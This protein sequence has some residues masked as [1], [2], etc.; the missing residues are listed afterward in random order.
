[1]KESILEP[2]WG[3]V[4][5]L[6]SNGGVVRSSIKIVKNK[7]EF[8]KD[9]ETLDQEDPDVYPP[10]D[11]FQYSTG[12]VISPEELM[13][14]AIDGSDTLKVALQQ[15]CKKY[16]DIFSREVDAIPAQVPQM[17]LE[18]AEDEWKSYK[19]IGSPRTQTPQAQAEIKRQ[20][21]ILIKNKIIVKS[22]AVHY[23][24]VVLAPKP[25]GK[26]RMCI[27]YKKLNDATDHN[28]WPA[29]Y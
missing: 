8:I 15:L 24:K 13:P 17:E 16:I 20:V 26:W 11:E 18:V 21:D 28:G 1:M 3:E 4:A 22:N 5:T 10:F 25:N 7:I 14:A 19:N 29:S 9:D 12:E 23:S 2:S 27:D 6:R